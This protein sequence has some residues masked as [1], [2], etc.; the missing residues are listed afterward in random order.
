[1]VVRC[2]HYYFK[3]ISSCEIASWRIPGLLEAYLKKT[4]NS[5]EQEIESII[6]VWVG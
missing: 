1:M 2:C 4:K 3:E 5:G 6:I